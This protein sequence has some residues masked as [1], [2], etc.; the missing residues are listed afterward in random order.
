[1]FSIKS[2]EL[3]LENQSYSMGCTCL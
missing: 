2:F 3:S 1:M